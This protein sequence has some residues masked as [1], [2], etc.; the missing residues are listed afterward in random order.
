VDSLAACRFV[1]LAAGLEEYAKAYT[2]VTGVPS[3]SQDLLALGERIC[4]NERI[5][6]YLNGFR[7]CEDDLPP[8]FFTEPGTSGGGVDIRPLDRRAF[9]E[10]RARYYAIRGLDDDACPLPEKAAALGLEL[11]Q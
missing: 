10:A 2:A 9:L 5:M 7:S 4:F 6:N 3:S 11:E 8:R 1:F